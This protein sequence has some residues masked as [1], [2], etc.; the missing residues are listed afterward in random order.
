MDCHQ[1]EHPIITNQT[2]IDTM[3]A[4]Q[5][6]FFVLTNGQPAKQYQHPP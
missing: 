1:T 6:A 5:L 3:I 2:F 4:L